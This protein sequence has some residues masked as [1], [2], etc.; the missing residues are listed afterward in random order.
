MYTSPV[1]YA[2][3]DVMI[4]DH[5]HTLYDTLDSGHIAYDIIDTLNDIMHNTLTSQ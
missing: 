5:V 1:L 2:C 3:S 4:V